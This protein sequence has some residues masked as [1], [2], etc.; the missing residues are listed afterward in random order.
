MKEITLYKS[1]GHIVQD[2]AAAAYI[3]ERASRK[4]RAEAR[5]TECVL[6]KNKLHWHADFYGIHR[7]ES[8][9]EHSVQ[10]IVGSPWD[11][12]RPRRLRSY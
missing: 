7:W 12:V 5:C 9:P 4:Q 3:H 6:P 2:L 8:C 1:L 11:V 10:T